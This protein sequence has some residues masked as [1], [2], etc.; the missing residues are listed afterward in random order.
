MAVQDAGSAR[1]GRLAVL[2]LGFAVTYCI[3]RARGVLCWLGC[4]VLRKV[5][6]WCHQREASPD[7]LM[8]VALGLMGCFTDVTQ[9]LV[10]I[11]RCF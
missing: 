6:V 7:E 10:I 2:P 4:V 1:I 3:R 5:V 8:K 9:A 11:A